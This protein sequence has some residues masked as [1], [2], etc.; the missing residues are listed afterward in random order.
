MDVRLTDDQKEIARQAQR[1]LENE[2]PIDH[3]RAMCEDD[4]GFKDEIWNRMAEMGWMGLLI[5][6][7]FSGL[8]MGMVDMVV[9]LEQ[10][11]C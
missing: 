11:V 2:C 1:L 10:M 5:P 3:V 4:R 8:G 7:Q 6:E 9:I